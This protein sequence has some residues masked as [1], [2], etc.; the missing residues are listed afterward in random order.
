[1]TPLTDDG[2][3][4]LRLQW[5]MGRP[6][7]IGLMG[8]AQT[9]KDSVATILVE[10]HGYTRIAFA[11]KLREVAYALNP[12]IGLR[13]TSPDGG[14]WPRSYLRLQDVVN[15]AGWDHAKTTYPEVRRLLQ[16]LG[17]EVGRQ[18]LSPALFGDDSLWVRA[19]IDNLPSARIVVTDVRFPNEAEAILERG[20]VLWRVE[21]RGYGPVNDHPSE[22]AVDHLHP[23][24][25][26]QNDGTLEDLATLVNGL[27]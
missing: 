12:I 22:T 14:A 10:H 11:D 1:M 5:A 3:T 23:N 6:A 9:G 24:A 13:H 18:V 16:A 20:G 21:R 26:L 15:S 4:Q 8:Y 7:L 19:A 25:T 27:L 2:I 17:T